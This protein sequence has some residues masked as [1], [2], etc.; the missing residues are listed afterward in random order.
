[1]NPTLRNKLIAA[2]GSGAIAIA[3]VLASNFEG[4]RYTP[5]RDP[6]G[7]WTVCEGITGPDVIQGKTYTDKECDDLRDKHLRIA[8]KAML[9]IV[10]VPLNDWQHAALIDFTYNAGAENLRTSTMARHFNARDYTG[11]CM[12]LMK[13]VKARVKGQLVTLNGL[14]TRRQADIEVCLGKVAP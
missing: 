2:A 4:R 5:Y 7:I 8:D 14:V 3:G 11:G 9:S 12:E 1:M 6:V 10:H 13:W